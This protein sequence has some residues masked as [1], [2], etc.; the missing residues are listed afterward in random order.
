[1]TDRRPAP[2]HRELAPK[3][4]AFATEYLVDLHQ[5]N[6]MKRAG[7]AGTDRALAVTASRLMKDPRIRALVDAGMAERAARVNITADQV[8]GDLQRVARKAEEEG[9]YSSAVRALELLGKHLA[10]FVDRTESVSTSIVVLSPYG[11][12]DESKTIG[13]S[14]SPM[15]STGAKPE[16]TAPRAPDQT[17]VTGEALAVI[18]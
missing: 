16:P 1:M 11:P 3:M 10:L 14:W 17:P 6:A 18:D 13:G 9:E 2:K 5:L 4:R 7:Y 12:R 15:P 8:L